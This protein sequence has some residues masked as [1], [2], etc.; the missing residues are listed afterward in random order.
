MLRLSDQLFQG[1]RVRLTAPE[2]EQDAAVE[3]A[4]TTD[5]EYLRLADAAPAR[6]QSAAQIKKRYEEQAKEKRHNR[7]AFAVRAAAAE[8]P[9]RL[10]GFAR[11][12]RIEWNNGAAW[13]ELGLGAAA[14]RRQGYGTETLDLLLRYAFDELN[15][16]RLAA[17]VAEYNAG[18]RRLLEKAGFQPEVRRRE[19][20]YRAGR[21]WDELWYGLLRPEWAARRPEAQS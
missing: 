2:P 5:P 9:E 10:I 14:D 17:S 18:A 21:R 11:L 15:L 7:I 6:P 20:L 12:H 3:A 16:H 8:G 13:L 19:A 1:A 4:W